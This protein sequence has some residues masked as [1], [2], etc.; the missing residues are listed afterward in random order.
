[1]KY[2]KIFVI[3]GAGFLGYHTCLRLVEQGREVTCL[4]MLDEAVDQSLSAQVH[5]VRADIDQLSNDSLMELLSGHDALVYAA[6]PDDRIELESGVKASEFFQTQLVDRTERTLRA[7]KLVGIKKAIIFGSYF[8]YINN[9]GLAGV[10]KG[11]LERHPYI[12]ARVDQTSRAFSLGDDDFS[13]AVLNI[14]YV[15]GTAP[16]KE[17]IWRKVFVE[18]FAS[19]PKIY[20]GNGGTTVVSAKKVAESASQAIIFAKHG[21][22]LAIGSRNMKFRPMIR[23]LLD[24]AKIDKPVGSLPNFLL[25]MVMRGQWKKMKQSGLDSGLDL[26][27]LTQDILKRNFYVD[28]MATDYKLATSNFPDDVDEA[29]SETGKTMQQETQVELDS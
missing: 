26:R 9:H 11:K 20:Y 16:G 7:A 6:G 8:S 5:L 10:T 25:S 3:G 19:S 21:D 18:K 1:M 12:K 27:Y 13:V 14:P 29:I 15:F 4:A 17:P 23:Q 22:E 28:F 24:E 2:Q